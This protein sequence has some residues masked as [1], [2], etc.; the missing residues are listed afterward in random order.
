MSY[1]PDAPGNL[2][3]LVL[4]SDYFNAARTSSN[5]AAAQIKFLC[6]LRWIDRLAPPAAVSG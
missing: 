5:S 2:E 3:T 4:A 1:L 6:L